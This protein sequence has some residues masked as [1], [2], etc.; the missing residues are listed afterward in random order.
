MPSLFFLLRLRVPQP[1]IS[2][3]VGLPA[4]DPPQR[5]DE[6]LRQTV[7]FSGSCAWSQELGLVIF[8]GPF[9]LGIFCDAAIL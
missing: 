7:Y 8:V 1:G 5:L 6:A 9:Q 2:H 3:G 4:Y